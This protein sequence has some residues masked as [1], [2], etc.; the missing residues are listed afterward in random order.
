MPLRVLLV[1][2]SLAR[3]G[4]KARPIRERKILCLRLRNSS[5]DTIRSGALLSVKFGAG[6]PSISADDSA[7]DFSEFLVF[8]SLLVIH[9]LPV[10]ILAVATFIRVAR[11]SNS[12]DFCDLHTLE[13]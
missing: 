12:K 6:V 3:L 13:I 4:N 9:Y 10:T 2:L 8:L 7:M 5:N 1:S 11:F